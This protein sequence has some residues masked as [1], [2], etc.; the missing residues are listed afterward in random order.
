MVTGNLR[1]VMAASRMEEYHELNS[2]VGGCAA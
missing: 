1:N 2:N